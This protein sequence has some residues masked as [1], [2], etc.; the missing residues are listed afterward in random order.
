MV[1]PTRL[2]Y[3]HRNMAIDTE[4][5]PAV[6]KSGE[7]GPRSTS[8][9]AP[10]KLISQV[11]D[12]L[13]KTLEF[14]KALDHLID[15]AIELLGVARA[16]IM[17]VDADRTHLTIKVGRGLSP[18]VI[19]SVRIPVGQGIAGTVA[20]T[21]EPLVVRDVRKLDQ[22]RVTARRLPAP[23]YQD[24]SALSVPLVIHGV[25]EGVMNFNH[26]LNG[27][28]LNLGD[29][30]LAMI[31][32]NQATVSLYMAKLH[33]EFLEKQALEHELRVAR[34]IQKRMQPTR[35]PTVSG[36]GFAAHSQM[37]HE[38]G[39]DYFD[40]YD[41]SEDRIGVAIGD[42]AGHGLGPALL[43]ADARA[44]IRSGFRRGDSLE[45]CLSEL[46]NLLLQ[47]TSQEHYMTMLL[48]ILDPSEGTF[49]LATA[50]HHLPIVLR[51]GDP[52]DLPKAG[53]NIPLGIRP[54]QVFFQEA[55]LQL[56][57]GDV[58]L[59]FTDGIWDAADAVGHRFGTLGLVDSL[60]T[61]AALEGTEIIAALLKAVA[62]HVKSDLLDDDCT[63][64][65][66]KVGSHPS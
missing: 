62:Q 48:G 27:T 14:D 22:W 64:V 10:L 45:D 46:N 9:K 37:C 51:N 60:R 52:L 55:R 33:H 47:E 50:G 26:K 24:F 41:L 40:F 3:N 66:L 23:D 32:A 21:G 8:S 1:S 65:T 15:G 49:E 5:R 63:L 53:V 54:D 4:L 13:V 2:G 39:G 36:Y 19:D 38:V 34:S 58:L 11:T 59:L 12:R 7:V 44:S 20:K 6:P 57:A 35:L 18:E 43:V 31:I 29:L 30:E 25:V 61:H 42:V 16:S 28:A 17:I 56:E